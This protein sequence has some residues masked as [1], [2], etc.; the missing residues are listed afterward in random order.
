MTL[1]NPLYAAIACAGILAATPV[2]AL[3]LRLATIAPEGHN[4]TMVARQIA[5]QLEAMPE[6]D[7][8]LTVFPGAQLGGEPETLQQIELGLIDMGVFTVASLATRAP[9]MNGWFTPYLFDD[10]ASAGAARNLPAAKAMIDE[11]SQTG[12]AG[13]GYTLAGMRH[14]LSRSEPVTGL[15]DVTAKKIRITPFDAAKIWW[16]ALG[17]VPTPIPAPSLYQA[18]QTGVV[19]LVEVDLDLL[20]ALSLYEVSGGL[21]LTGHMVFPGGIVISQTVYDRLSDDQKAGLQKAVAAATDIGIKAQI[22]AETKNLETVGKHIKVV[23]L[24]KDAAGFDAGVAAFAK[25]YGAIP[26]VAEFQRQV[27]EARK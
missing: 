17:V 18:L 25:A 9:S 27:A 8:H 15:A 13:L 14:I 4:W 26:L 23:T 21:S 20:T 5:T 22:E 2:A 3:D 10:V 24:D 11:L 7:L 16:E 6:L 19:D 12:I 1:R